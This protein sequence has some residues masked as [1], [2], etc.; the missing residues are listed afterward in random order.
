MV[1][2]ALVAKNLSVIAKVLVALSNHYQ[3]L[4]K[5]FLELQEPKALVVDKNY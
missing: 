5:L 3:S 4:L 2:N 1:D